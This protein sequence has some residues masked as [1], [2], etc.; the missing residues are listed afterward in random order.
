[1][2]EGLGNAIRGEVRTRLR[3]RKEILAM[4]TRH[5]VVNDFDEI[6]RF[7]TKNVAD[8]DKRRASASR[9]LRS[10]DPHQD[11]TTIGSERKIVLGQGRGLTRPEITEQ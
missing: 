11:G 8:R 2:S 6:I 4:Y 1:M 10:S 7:E 3:R 5:I 9:L